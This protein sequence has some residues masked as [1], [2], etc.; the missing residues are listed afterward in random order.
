MIKTI[1][2]L[3]LLG[4]LFSCDKDPLSNKRVKDV[5]GETIKEYTYSYSGTM[6]WY[7]TWYKIEKGDDGNLRLLYSKDCE[8]EI[9]IYKCPADA[10]KKIDGFVRQYKLWNLKNS[11]QPKM[12]ILDGY[13]WHTSI[14]Y[15]DA[16]L[17]TGGFNAWPPKEL[18]AGLST[19]EGY[20][21][22]IIDAATDADIIGTDS[23]FNRN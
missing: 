1:I 16:W 17:S 11:Y 13:S 10:L 23:H 8:P 22:S 21:K 19:I 4:A 6:M 9:T 2:A 7:I 3:S 20:V 12:D 18:S 14:T 5:P 15:E